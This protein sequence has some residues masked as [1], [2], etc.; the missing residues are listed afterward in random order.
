MMSTTKQNCIQ[1]SDHIEK[2]ENNLFRGHC[3]W[4]KWPEKFLEQKQIKIWTWVPIIKS[5]QVV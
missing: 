2:K 1:I 3:G 5:N 4:N